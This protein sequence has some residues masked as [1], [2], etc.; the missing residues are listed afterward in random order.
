MLVI[1]PFI[2]LCHRNERYLRVTLLQQELVLSLIHRRSFTF[3]PGG[4]HT[5][6]P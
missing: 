5:G 4:A 1:L 6:R 3:L 2:T